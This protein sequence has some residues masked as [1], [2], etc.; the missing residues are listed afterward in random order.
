MA[1]CLLQR[2]MENDGDD[3]DTKLK[4]EI[5]AELDK[6]SISSLEKDDVDSD[7]KSDIQSDDSDTVSVK[8]WAFKVLTGVNFVGEILLCSVFLTLLSH[9]LTLGSLLSNVHC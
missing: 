9:F 4:E 8:C 5:E 2:M 1:L 7:S 3:D 6:I